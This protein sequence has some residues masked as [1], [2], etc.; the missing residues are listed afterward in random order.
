M[1]VVLYPHAKIN[2]GLKIVEK[3]SDGFHNLETL[4]YPVHELC[5][6]LEIIESGGLSLHRYGAPLSLPGDDIENEL[7]VRAYRLIE[8]DFRIPPVEIHLYKKIPVCAGLGGG[9]SDAVNMLI[10]LN[11]L[12]DLKLTEK[13][14]L[15]YASRLGSDCPFFIYDRPMLGKG[16]G[17]I[18]VPVHSQSVDEIGVKYKIRT[19]IPGIKISTAEAYAGIVP[20]ASGRGLLQKALSMPVAEWK[21]RVANDFEKNI[22]KKYPE[23][24]E[25]K[26]RLY[27]EGAVYASMSGSG[28]ALYGLFL[29]D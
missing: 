20:D 24:Q 27:S 11:V 13:D 1:N 5:D 16:K 6:I 3:R 25:E 17:D 18:L 21:G 4:F 12:F 10:G 15:Q 19:V 28:P 7:C 2:I 8:K 14:L 22:F 9:S 23:L 26:E 29:T